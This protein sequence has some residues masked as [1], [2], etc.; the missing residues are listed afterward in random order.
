M[1]CIYRSDVMYYSIENG[2]LNYAVSLTHAGC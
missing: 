1:I 2:N